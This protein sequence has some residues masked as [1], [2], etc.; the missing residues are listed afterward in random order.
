M[1][2]F[3]VI[4]IYFPAEIRGY[5]LVLIMIMMMMMMMIMIIIMVYLTDPINL[6]DK[7]NCL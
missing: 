3:A 6:T 7:I 2:L 5:V 1:W 4:T